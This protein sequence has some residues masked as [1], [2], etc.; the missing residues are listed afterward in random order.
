MKLRMKTCLVIASTLACLVAVVYW[1]TSTVFL[2]QFIRLEREHI[3]RQAQRLREAYVA[4]LDDL[5]L[6]SVDWAV[7]DDSYKFVQDGNG[8]YI[9]SNL[10]DTTFAD[11]ELNV[12]VF[13][14]RKGRVVFKKGFDLEN[15]QEVPLPDELVGKHLVKGAP[16]AAHRKVNSV[17]KGILLLAD[18]PMLVVSRP[19]VTSE[20]RGP[21]QGT[22]VFGRFFDSREIGMLAKRTLLVIEAIRPDI[23]SE[24][25]EDIAVVRSLTA[26]HPVAVQVLSRD[27][28]AG[29]LM[30]EDI[31]G[32]RVMI[33]KLKEQRRIYHQ[34][35]NSLYYLIGMLIAVGAAFIILA[36]FLMDLLVLRRLA[37]FAAQVGGIGDMGDM[38]AR[39]SVGGKDELAG[40]ASAVNQ[41]LVAL[42]TL[43][44]TKEQFMSFLSH[45]LRTPLAILKEAVWSL[46]D[47]I[48]GPLKPEQ[49]ELVRVCCHYAD[50]MKR[51][52]A[53]VL[54]LS[55]LE[56]GKAAAALK[57]VDAGALTGDILK[58][59]NKI[60][61]SSRIG[62]EME[63][64]EKLP[65][66]LADEDM[67]RQVLINLLNNAVRFARERV[68]V[69][70]R[71]VADG[72]GFGG[73][74]FVQF[75]VSDDGPG[76]APERATLLFDKF[77]QI[78]RVAERG[79][80]KGTGLGLVISKEI[81]G[82]HHGR[83]WL[84]SRPGEGTT[85]SFTLPA[86]T[87]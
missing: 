53:N 87:R 77:A 37:K 13:L 41:M 5:A 7:W 70:A 69:R 57:A 54:E 28:I 18:R 78:E 47:G 84:E 4:K 59:L 22:L 32:R 17:K 79:G 31:Y 48:A 16:L 8:A 60:M 14:D 81:I 68:V 52:I 72:Q 19:V 50:Q 21:I 33:L 15:R 1:F 74:G 67:I 73:D 10:G 55:R 35:R 61:D 80:Y 45:E 11:L 30:L 43:S 51:M 26:S 66:V 49:A 76:I 6:K 64:Q 24:A 2:E 71:A 40:L 25:P 85:F 86:A 3:T 20:R 29:Y 39:V 9:E 82:L 58:S 44:R 42:D 56:S 63:F 27:M 36:Y 38:G 83:I 46:Q 23:K 62:V 34:G 65:L 75:S 12:M